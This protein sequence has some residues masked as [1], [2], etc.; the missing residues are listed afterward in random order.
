MLEFHVQEQVINEIPWSRNYLL[1]FCFS[2]LT[3]IDHFIPSPDV[4]PSNP[5][6]FFLVSFVLVCQGSC[7]CP[8]LHSRLP[9]PFFLLLPW[10]LCLICS[11]CVLRSPAC[12]LG[13]SFL[14][15]RLEAKANSAFLSSAFVI[16]QSKSVL[17]AYFLSSTARSPIGLANIPRLS[18][19]KD[20]YIFLVVL[21]E[22]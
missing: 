14:V 17:M 4:D 20:E 9:T 19:C 11:T 8:C 13:T 18:P 1:D 3:I 6:I 12:F 7:S 2:I 15:S 10:L 21:T 5:S 16:F 22:E